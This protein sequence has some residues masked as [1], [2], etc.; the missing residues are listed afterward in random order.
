MDHARLLEEHIPYRLQAVGVLALAWKWWNTWEAPKQAQV[1]FD[2]QLAIEG[3]SSAI[4]NPMLEAGFVHARALLEFL[5]LCVKNGKL[6]NIERRRPDDIGI[7][8]FSVNGRALPMVT[9]SAAI[10]T[11]T[12]PAED[13]EQALMSVFHI[14]NK[15]FAHFSY[16]L[17]QGRWSASN[18]AIACEGI[19]VLVI[20]TLYVPLGLPPPEYEPRSRPR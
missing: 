5:G 4:L 7:E 11:Y 15:G 20:N 2:G 1:F 10:R 19:P 3:N 9:P 12:G 6:A 13:A 18:V 16:G 14:A 8:S 17:T